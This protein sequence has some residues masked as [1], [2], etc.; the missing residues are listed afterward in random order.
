VGHR[1][2]RL[3]LA[4][5]RRGLHHRHAGAIAQPAIRAE[6]DADTAIF[7]DDFSDA[8]SGLWGTGD[9][10]QG[11]IAYADGGLRVEFLQGEKSLWSWRELGEAWD[12]VRVGGRVTLGE[13]P[14]AAGWMCGTGADDLVG[15]V[16]NTNGEWV[17]IEIVAGRTGAL[18]RGPLPSTLPQTSEHEVTLECAGTGT[19]ALRMRMAVDGQ[20]V[21]TLERPTG[22]A[23]FDRVAVYA[24]TTTPG[25]VA[26]FD[27]AEASGGSQFGGF[28]DS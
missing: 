6:P 23:S 20:Q 24:D 2:H 16:M 28:P 21:A 11:T 4:T 17:F 3:L 12:V 1:L 7:T 25:F 15:A 13:G 22:I 14:G 19:G 10:A 18:D 9:R 8:D 27:D 26:A 5:A